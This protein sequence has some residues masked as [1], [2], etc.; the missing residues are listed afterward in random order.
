MRP[1]FRR[2]RHTSN[3]IYTIV[4][5]CILLV[6]LCI[7][8]LIPGD[9]GSSPNNTDTPPSHG[10][11]GNTVGSENTGQISQS[12]NNT[13]SSSGNNSASGQVN[14]HSHTDSYITIT[15]NKAK[16][17][18][19]QETYQAA[20]PT[21]NLEQIRVQLQELALAREQL[22][23]EREE[24]RKLYETASEELSA[25]QNDYLQKQTELQTK[26]ELLKKDLDKAE[27]QL[28]EY[29][30]KLV[31]LAAD[32]KKLSEEEK[33]LQETENHLQQLGEDI[34]H[35]R[36][37]LTKER[38]DLESDIQSIK[39]NPN[40][41]P[42]NKETAL[43]PLYT[44]LE[45]LLVQEVQLEHSE[46]EYKDRTEALLAQKENLFSRLQS[47]EED[48]RKL[49]EDLAPHKQIQQ[50]LT[51][52]LKSAE[53]QLLPITAELKRIETEKSVLEKEYNDKL[54]TLDAEEKRIT[55]E[56]QTLKKQTTSQ[57]IVS[58]SGNTNSLNAKSS[59]A[60]GSAK[61]S[62]SVQNT[63]EQ[64]VQDVHIL[65]QRTLE[66]I[67]ILLQDVSLSEGSNIASDILLT[68]VAD[69]M[70]TTPESGAQHQDVSRTLPDSS[71]ED[72]S[73]SH[74]DNN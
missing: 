57:Q 30:D 22:I 28:A 29:N 61:P 45:K 12:E 33:K 20:P 3:W 31:T 67:L 46:A 43:V 41:S 38:R 17:S 42:E 9:S 72:S 21:Q 35:A 51:S 13:E 50:E 2:R 62:N 65:A 25:E 44:K 16:L 11:S 64:N 48:R 58:G 55:Q 14:T 8:S 24:F 23:A 53:S 10:S 39:E 73:G 63:S 27:V 40:Q 47:H 52:A 5:V 6:T 36:E 1:T 66:R 37:Q 69:I 56:E 71:E 54:V 34:T 74:K 70:I 32:R 60:V 4:A 26:A 15:I 7:L 19:L 68:D 59:S 49:E 18:A